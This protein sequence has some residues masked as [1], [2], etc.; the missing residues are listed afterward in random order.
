MKAFLARLFGLRKKTRRRHDPMFCLYM[1]EYNGK[2]RFT[3]GRSTLA[4][5]PRSLAEA[6][7]PFL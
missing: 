7:N 1:G 4:R 6:N 3:L 5:T 2:R